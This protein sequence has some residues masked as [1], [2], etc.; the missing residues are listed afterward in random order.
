M[1]CLVYRSRRKPG[2]YLFVRDKDIVTQLPPDLIAIF[3]QPEFSFEFEL[4]PDRELARTDAK[5]VIQSIERNGYHLQL[6][7]PESI[8]SDDEVRDD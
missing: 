2:A 5:T 6:P 3:G 8:V 1:Q 4:T 7:P